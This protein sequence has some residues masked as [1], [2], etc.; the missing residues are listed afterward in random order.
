MYP[1]L[2][3]FYH[4][5]SYLISTGIKSVSQIT[6]KIKLLPQDFSVVRRAAK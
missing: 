1:V 3:S 4:I 2:G 6:L 5:S